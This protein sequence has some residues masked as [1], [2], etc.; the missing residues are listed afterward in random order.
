MPGGRPGFALGSQ[1]RQKPSLVYRSAA[2]GAD[3]ANVIQTTRAAQYSA[4]RRALHYSQV[5]IK[6]GT[7][8]E[9]MVPLWTFSSKGVVREILLPEAY[10]FAAAFEYPV[11]PSLTDIPTTT[12]TQA[13][14]PDGGNIYVSNPADTATKFF[15]FR[16]V[17]PVEIPPRS[18]YGTWLTHECVA[19]RTGAVTDKLITQASQ[20]SGFVNRHEGASA[21]SIPGAGH[22]DSNFCMTST[23]IDPIASAQTGANVAMTVGAIRL[24][25]PA[26]E[27]SALINGNSIE[28][29]QQEGYGASGR[30]GDASGDLYNN[31]GHAM[32]LLWKRRISVSQMS[33]GSDRDSYRLTAG[34]YAAR[35]AWMAETNPTHVIDMNPNNEIA[36]NLAAAG[37]WAAA[38]AYVQDAVVFSGSNLYICDTGG[39]SGSRGPTGT[40]S[41]LAD[42]TAVW[43]YILPNDLAGSRKAGTWVGQRRRRL[44]LDRAALPHAKFIGV[45]QPPN[46]A[47][48]QTTTIYT[49]AGTTLTVTLGNVDGYVVGMNARLSSV[50]GQTAFTPSALLSPSNGFSR[51]TAVD[52][53]AKTVSFT[54]PSGLAAPANPLSVNSEWTSVAGQTPAADYA[55]GTSARSAINRFLRSPQ[56]ATI[57][58]YA[59]LIDLGAYLESGGPTTPATETGAWKTY[60]DNAIPVGGGA[61][62]DGTHPTSRSFEDAAVQAAN[63][64]DVTAAFAK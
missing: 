58:G 28:A 2:T 7:T 25:M 50:S 45:T 55:P 63:D 18:V 24:P 32:R 36:R 48:V 29:G 11:A 31:H 4:T 6:A 35:L 22:I 54:V 62:Y 61:T 38:T 10:R 51:V 42:G 23:S 27:R 12:R 44:R 41:G 56:A 16:V 37:G 8:I 21:T 57:L 5:G 46:S 33:K 26:T 53:V 1:P 9:L 52:P 60:V 19:G 64:A 20:R 40:G 43:S 17:V 13:V 15:K 14:A 34:N 47:S 39:T 49:Y 59:G 30:F 3:A